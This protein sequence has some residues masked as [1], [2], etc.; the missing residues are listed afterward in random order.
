VQLALTDAGGKG[1][2][3][4][5]AVRIY[6]TECKNQEAIGFLV[7]NLKKWMPDHKSLLTCVGVSELAL[8]GMRV[9]IEAYAHDEEAK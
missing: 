3:Q 9:E 2:S 7:Q 8:E 6:T 4:V 1:W 5:Y